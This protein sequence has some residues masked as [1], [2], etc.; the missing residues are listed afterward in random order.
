MEIGQAESARTAT[1]FSGLLAPVFAFR[2]AN[3]SIVDRAV[4]LTAIAPGP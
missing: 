2:R 3:G 1:F 4:F